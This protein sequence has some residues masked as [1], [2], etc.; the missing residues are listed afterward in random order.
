MLPPAPP[1]KKIKLPVSFGPILSR[2]VPTGICINE[3][4]KNQN[5]MA[6]ARSSD[7]APISRDN[8][9][10]SIAKK[11]RKNWLITYARQSK[12]M[13]TRIPYDLKFFAE[14]FIASY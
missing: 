8:C 5:P 2:A 3:N 14:S 4:V 1:N 6:K 9:S 12:I 10:L 7:V 13:P 11:L